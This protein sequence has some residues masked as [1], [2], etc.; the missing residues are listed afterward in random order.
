MLA[1]GGGRIEKL[2]TGHERRGAASARFEFGENNAEYANMLEKELSSLVAN[3]SAPVDR[4]PHTVTGKIYNST[5]FG[6]LTLPSLLSF[7]NRFVNDGTR[8]IP[9]DITN[10]FTVVSLAF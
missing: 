7:Y 5:K 2:A 6:T 8:V 4:P 9:S 10:G 3:S 1:G